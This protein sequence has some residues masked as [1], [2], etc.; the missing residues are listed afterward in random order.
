V[1]RVAKTYCRC[2]SRYASGAKSAALPRTRITIQLFLF[3]QFHISRCKE[4]PAETQAKV[5]LKRE[6]CKFGAKK[7]PDPPKGD[8]KRNVT[9]RKPPAGRTTKAMDN[10]LNEVS[11]KAMKNSA[12]SPCRPLHLFQPYSP[13]RSTN[14]TPA[15]LEISTA[16]SFFSSN[17]NT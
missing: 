4:C 1:F 11:M 2:K 5:C 6:P 13:T 14:R 9:R 16:P 3:R 10:R 12:P 8:E 17:C 15:R 7:K